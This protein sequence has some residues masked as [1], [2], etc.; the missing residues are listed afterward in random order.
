MHG[1]V[2]EW[3]QD[4]YKFGY[5]SAPVD[6]SAAATNTRNCSRVERGGSFVDEPFRLRSASRFY[7]P[8]FEL[9]TGL[10]FRVGLTLPLTS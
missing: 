10:G 4:C 1:N 6:G 7:S 3:V 8:T 5:E 9:F 2:W